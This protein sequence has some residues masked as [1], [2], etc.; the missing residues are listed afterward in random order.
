MARNAHLEAAKYHLEAASQHLAAVDRYNE[1]DP[2]GAERHSD[3][4]RLTSQFADVKSMEAHTMAMMAARA[5][6]V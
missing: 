1:G 3:E 2:D 5:K 6:L 4:A